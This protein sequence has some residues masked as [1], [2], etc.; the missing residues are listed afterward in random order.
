MLACAAAHGGTLEKIRETGRIT[1]GVRSSSIPFSFVN[2]ENEPIGYVVDLCR[3]VT[4]AIR[5]ELSLPALEV[6]YRFVTLEDRYKRLAA[7]DI[8]LECASSSNTRSRYDE[9][10]FS[11]NLF[12][13][14]I[15]MVV[16]R[17]SGIHDFEDLTGKKVVVTTNSTTER[18]VRQIIAAGHWKVDLM[19]TGSHSESFRLVKS[20]RAAAFVLDDVL[21]AGLIAVS[22]D[23]QAYQIV[24]APLRIEPYALAMRKDDPEFK[25]VVD[26]ALTQAMQSGEAERLYDRWFMEPIPPHGIN[27]EEPP[28]ETLKAAFR[29]PSDEGAE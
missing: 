17:G 3:K 1:L 28:S 18:L 15:R 2:L 5:Q 20:G 14:N 23:P 27:L 12:Y 25:A 22:R 8:D 11:V 10:A 24:G 19:T 4:E 6:A 29:N 7:G 21:L 9:A 26:R 13:V 16:R